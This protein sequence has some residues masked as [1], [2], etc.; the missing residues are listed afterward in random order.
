MKSTISTLLLSISLS[1]ILLLYSC[2]KDGVQPSGELVIVEGN[3]QTGIKGEFLTE[4]VVIQVTSLFSHEDIVLSGRPLEGMGGVIGELSETNQFIGGI[5]VDENYQAEVYLRL[6]CDLDNQVFEL[7]LKNKACLL[8]EDCPALATI[9]VNTSGVEGTSA[10]KLECDLQHIRHVREHNGTTY[11]WSSLHPFFGFSPFGNFSQLLKTNDFVEW[12]TV[13]ELEVQVSGFNILADGSMII[14]TNYGLKESADGVTWENLN[15]EGIR[16][17]T[18]FF[19]YD[20][21]LSEDTVLFVS[22]DQGDLYRTRDNG[23]NWTSVYFSSDYG[24]LTRVVNGDLYLYD[25][26]LGSLLKSSDSGD[27]WEQVTIQGSMQGSVRR[28]IAAENNT[29]LITSSEDAFLDTILPSENLYSLDLTTH[30]LEQVTFSQ[31]ENPSISD[32]RI[33]DGSIY[34]LSNNDIYVFTNAWEKIDG[35]EISFPAINRVFFPATF[36]RLYVKS[37]SELLLYGPM[38]YSNFIN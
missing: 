21:I 9:E 27:T 5:K 38:V 15:D 19:V 3:N 1:S 12:T 30:A 17:G 18:D 6:D 14:D 10:W 32:I 25:G 20:M 36:R 24:P 22:V 33:N 28:M 8:E 26:V 29:L 16:A 23:E 4:P 31:D 34:I 11:A 35:P 13:A 2:D 7:T 37:Q